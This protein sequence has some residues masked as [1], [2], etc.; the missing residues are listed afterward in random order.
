LTAAF[1]YFANKPGS[2]SLSSGIYFTTSATANEARRRIDQAILKYTDLLICSTATTG[3]KLLRE[4]IN[5]KQ[6]PVLEW[7]WAGDFTERQQALRAARV[8]QTAE[9][10]AQS[11]EYKEWK[12]PQSDTAFNPVLIATGD[13]IF[14]SQEPLTSL[15]GAGKTVMT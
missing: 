15:A 5:K 4:N 7:I 11:P 3:T 14:P 12:S 13:R 10:F 2:G 8:D 9:W 6:Q 1:D